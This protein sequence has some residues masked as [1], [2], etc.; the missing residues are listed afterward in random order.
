M[1]ISRALSN[2]SL[3]LPLNYLAKFFKLQFM[4]HYFFINVPI[5][6][7]NPWPSNAEKREKVDHLNLC[8]Q[9]DYCVPFTRLSLVDS[10]PLVLFPKL[11]HESISPCK[12]TSN[13]SI[14]KKEPKSYFLEKLLII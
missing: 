4:H 2:A 5:S 11:W 14:F 8:L 13:K 7:L 9:D 3:I 12:S 6:Y 1:L 10:H